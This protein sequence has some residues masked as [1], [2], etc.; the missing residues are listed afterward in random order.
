MPRRRP[1]AIS[2]WAEPFDPHAELDWSRPEYSRRLLREHLDQS[3][4]GASRRL[5]QVGAHVRRLAR[6]LPPPPA[7]ILDAGCGP[8]LYATRLAKLGYEVEGFDVSPAAIRHA[9]SD[10]RRLH[11]SGRTSFRRQ[12][13]AG[14]NIGAEFDAA[15]LIYFVLE[16]F[17][18]A[19]QPQVLRRIARALL[20]QGKL[21]AELRLRPDQPPG[22]TT[23]WD[24]VDESVLSD[25]RHL[26]LG[27]AL[28]E[29]RRHTYVLREIAVFDDGRVAAQQTSG[30]LCPFESIPALFGRAGL[31]VQRMY[32]AWTGHAATALSESVLV[33]AR[34]TD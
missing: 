31:R 15:L 20:P 21:V 5:G 3:H 4:D 25:R 23:W 8:G 30:W 19:K 34:R 16:A 22:R 13:L 17:P 32:D 7:R 24:V 10:A 29:P 6:L 2:A 14:L 12:D 18:R 1:S 28:Y 33:V 27:D 26:L 9:R 11:V